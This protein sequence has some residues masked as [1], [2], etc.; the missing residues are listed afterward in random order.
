M[1]FVPAAVLFCLSLPIFS[2]MAQNTAQCP[3]LPAGSSLQWQER[4]SGDLLVC[5]ASTGEGREVMSLMLSRNDPDIPL[6]RAL[7]QERDSFAGETMYWYQPDLGGQEPPGFADRRIS[8]VK[9]DKNRYAQ[10]SLYPA[11]SEER[12]G[13]QQMVRGMN[14][15]PAAVAAGR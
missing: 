4:V 11:N 8:V 14:L 9:I 5:R 2:A 3:S 13:L 1:N 10:L 12:S 7:R 6:P 15:T